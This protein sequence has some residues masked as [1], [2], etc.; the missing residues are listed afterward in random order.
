MTSRVLEPSSAV[1]EDVPVMLPS[2]R[3]RLATRPVPTGSL[4]SYVVGQTIVVDGGL[5]L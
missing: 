2:G 3:A 5:I 4:A 1:V